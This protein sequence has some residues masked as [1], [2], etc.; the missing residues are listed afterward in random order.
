M[1]TFT[2]LKEKLIELTHLASALSVLNWDKETH[3]PAQGVALRAQTISTL[4]TVLHE[5][6]TSPEFEE[7][8]TKLKKSSDN[9]KLDEIEQCVIREIWRDFSREKKLPKEF[10]AELSRTV[11][12]AHHDWIEAK[13]KSDFSIFQ[14]TLEKIVVLK[15]KEAE[16][17]G[18]TG[19]PYNALLDQYEQGSTTEDLSILFE[20][21]KKFLVP[22]IKKIQDTNS[23]NQPDLLRGN[24]SI[25]KQ[26]E[27]SRFVLE[28]IGF[29]FNTGRIDESAHPFTTSFSPEDVRITTRFSQHNIFYS[30][31]STIHEAGHALY[32][33]GL[34]TQHFGTPLGE[35]LSLGIHESQSRMWENIIGKSKPF[36]KYFYPHLRKYFPEPF[37]KI[38]IDDFYK[39]LNTVKPSLIRTEADEATYNLHII[40]RFEIEKELIE[41]TIEVKDLPQ[42]WNQKV[43]DLL[44]IEVPGD[45]QGVLQDVHWSSGSIGYF[46]TYTLGNLYAAQFYHSAKNQV[47]NLEEE[48]AKGE[49][50]HLIE[51]LRK[52]IH[53]HGR[54]YSQDELAQQA[55]GEK[56]NTRYF[57][58]YLRNKYKDG[59]RPLL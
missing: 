47:L 24:Y 25:E 27:F 12:E 19:S 49:F 1:S 56:L 15:R 7:L 8:I 28:K 4:A 5:K 57:T 13:K 50:G 53:V 45:S 58:E 55:T 41:G 40:I 38:S 48:I 44:G 36:W 32:E 37:A 30:L 26:K 9:N 31:L 29:N 33:Q 22:F 34:E 52:N 51:W 54:F 6:F 14:P 17:V 11:A 20:E 16:L 39:A 46:P 10:V 35:A 18:Y 43:K 23:E 3:M 21:L 42:I 2:I 59:V